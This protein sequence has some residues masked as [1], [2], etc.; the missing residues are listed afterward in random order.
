MSFIV[1]R[2]GDLPIKHKIYAAAIEEFNENGIRFTMDD[3]ARRMKISKRTLYEQISSKEEL[4]SEIIDAVFAD[5][6]EKQSAVATNP[7]MHI[8]DKVRKVVSLMPQNLTNIDY[9]RVHEIAKFY[10]EQYAKINHL[11]SG[12][13]DTMLSLTQEAAR[14]NVIRPVNTGLLRKMILGTFRSL[15][16]DEFLQDQRL[17]YEEALDQALDIIF[18][19]IKNGKVR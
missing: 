9:S 16:D 6:H 19:G 11:L 5:I 3:L 4:I 8:L 15:L 18:N 10:P 13:W 1:F 17:T 7:D 14:Q 12:G 2:K